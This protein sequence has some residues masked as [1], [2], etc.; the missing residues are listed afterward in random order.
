MFKI[1]KYQ[2]LLYFSV[3]TNKCCYLTYVIIHMEKVIY[4]KQPIIWFA[5][6]LNNELQ[7]FDVLKMSARQDLWTM[8][9]GDGLSV[10][11][12]SM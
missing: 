1:K 3:L 5:Y 9:A 7:G 12:T 4:S 10:G 8:K 2:K 11:L 6:T